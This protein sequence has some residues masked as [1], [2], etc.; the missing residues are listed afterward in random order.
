MEKIIDKYNCGICV[1]PKNVLQI[2]EAINYLIS[3]K[4]IAYQMGQ[5]ARKAIEKEFNWQSQEKE[6]T[7]LFKRHAKK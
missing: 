6:Y 1:E 5:N 4:K 7:N 3:N 2:R